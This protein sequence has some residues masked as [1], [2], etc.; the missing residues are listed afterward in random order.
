MKFLLHKLVE[1][2]L[3]PV[4]S[5]ENTINV[6][7]FGQYIN[8]LILAVYLCI[9]I[10]HPHVVVFYFYYFYLSYLKVFFFSSSVLILLRL[11]LYFKEALIFIFDSV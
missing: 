5:S 4:I 9:S 6:D 2:W 11:I 8:A 7:Y 3:W 1:A 10:F